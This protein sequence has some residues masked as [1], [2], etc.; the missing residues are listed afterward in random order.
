[1]MR[2]KEHSKRPT[3]RRYGRWSNDLQ[4]I[5]THMKRT[6]QWMLAAIPAEGIGQITNDKSQMTN[7]ILRDGEL[8]I[9]SN[10]RYYNVSGQ[11][12]SE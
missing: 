1:M 7:K 5:S 3:S 11:R 10:G 9:E 4:T 12:V 6:T 2:R 8:I